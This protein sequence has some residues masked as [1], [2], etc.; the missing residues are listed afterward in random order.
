MCRCRKMKF[1]SRGDALAYV[2]ES[3][4]TSAR[5]TAVHAYRCAEGVWHLTSVPPAIQ[6]KKKR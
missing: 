5:M 6:R 3:K 2:R 4:R 1:T